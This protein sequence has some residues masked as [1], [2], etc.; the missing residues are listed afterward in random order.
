MIVQ[1]HFRG[2]EHKATVGQSRAGS[3]VASK[4]NSAA[5][6]CILL[7]SDCLALT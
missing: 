1:L 3:S 7:Q 2:Y 4:S 6:S 5:A